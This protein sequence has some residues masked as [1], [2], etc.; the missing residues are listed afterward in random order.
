MGEE[1]R[2][3]SLNVAIRLVVRSG[4]TSVVR[5]E[6]P[7]STPQA[8]LAAKEIEKIGEL[9]VSG[10]DLANLETPNVSI[11]T[12]PDATVEVELLDGAGLGVLPTGV[13]RILD[14]ETK[15]PF[16]VR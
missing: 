9:I 5:V 10:F 1:A 6:I 3:R 16:G 15:A 13:P 8:Q 12:I 14:L 4:K 2:G 11:F 7:I